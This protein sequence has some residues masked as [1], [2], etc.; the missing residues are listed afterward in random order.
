MNL[1]SI[2]AIL[3]VLASTSCSNR[4]KPYDVVE[5]YMLVQKAERRNNSIDWKLVWEDDFDKGSLDTT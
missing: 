2:L 5:G 1:R 4:S 3:L